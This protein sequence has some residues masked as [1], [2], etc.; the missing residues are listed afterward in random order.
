VPLRPLSI[1]EI[2]DGAVRA[3]RANPRTM[4]GFSTIVIALL[5]LLATAPQAWFLAT[6]LNSPLTD[7]ESADNAEISDVANLAGAGG[8]TVLVAVLQFVVATTIVS[9]LLIV[10]VDG[11][12][13]GRSMTPRELWVRC[14]SRLWAVLGVAL[15]VVLALP[16]VMALAL[17]PGL[18]VLFLPSG[19]VAGVI[20]LVLGGIAGLLAC[21]ALYFGF[22]AVAA[23]ALLLENLG[24]FASL[25]R[26]YQLVRGSFWRVLGIGLLT[27]VI[28]SILRQVFGV[29]FSVAGALVAGAGAGDDP[30]FVVT[31]IQLLVAG[32]GE[33]IAGAVLF[34]FT[35][36]VSA[37]LYLDLRM[38]REGLDVDLM[39]S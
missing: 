27:A 29:P 8:L 39:R 6:L 30:G 12:V 17:A 36:G 3:I 34:P 1:G 35:A 33:V 25:R 18:I 4:V 37:L 28:A 31:L 13:H 24:V 9:G 38:R 10:A 15:I 23:P 20:L 11:A 22:W 32:I 2:Y 19:T 21:L 7:P 16:L 14:R 5:T 26:S